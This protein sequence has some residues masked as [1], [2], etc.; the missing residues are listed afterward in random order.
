MSIR[1]RMMFAALAWAGAAFAGRVETVLRD[2][3]TCDGEPVTVPHTWN[4]IDAADGLGVPTRFNPKVL[5]S[6][7]G[8]VRRA[9]WRRD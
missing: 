5:D 3:W 7:G 8:L 4:A 1:L 2:G 9:K 6:A